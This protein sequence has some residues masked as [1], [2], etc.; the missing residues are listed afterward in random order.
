[1]RK[2][3]N[4]IISA[5]LAALLLV[6]L[7][8]AVFAN[9]N[10]S[11]FFVMDKSGVL[12]ESDKDEINQISNILF[13]Q[14][15][16]KLSVAVVDFLGGKTIEQYSSDLY[17]NNQMGSNGLLM[18]FSIAEENY[19]VLQ[20]TDIEHRLTDVQ[21]KDMLQAVV[22]S[23]FENGEYRNAVMSFYGVMAEKLGDIYSALID[24]QLY[25]DW[26]EEQ[27]LPVEQRIAQRGRWF[28]VFV[29]SMVA[30][31]FFTALMITFTVVKTR[32]KKK[33]AV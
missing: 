1:M 10:D 15:G 24:P 19:H 11:S 9:D 33:R 4:V 14:T 5:F 7:A 17:M 18:V 29:L 28:A 16:C 23:D 32:K 12:T 8:V 27:R 6:F 30:V 31:S 2:I 21:L 25:A 3:S 22:E 20:G 26:L 13:E